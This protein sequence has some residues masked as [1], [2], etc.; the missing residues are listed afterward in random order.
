[1]LEASPRP[2]PLPIFRT[3]LKAWGASVGIAIKTIVLIHPICVSQRPRSPIEA[4][5]ATVDS[6]QQRDALSGPTP[7]PPPPPPQLE[8][9]N[10]KL[11]IEQELQ[12]VI[13]MQA[14]LL[15]RAC[16]SPSVPQPWPTAPGRRS[17]SRASTR[18]RETLSSRWRTCSQSRCL[19]VPRAMLAHLPDHA[20]LTRAT[21]VDAMGH[22]AGAGQEGTLFARTYD[23]FVG[24]CCCALVRQTDGTLVTAL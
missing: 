13:A 16:H 15:S 17:F 12:Y 4:L 7:P 5:Q 20:S 10:M 23:H 9:L 6:E 19:D 1:M 2:G 14:H 21:Q 3:R 24:G 22:L 8:V 11:K 18:R